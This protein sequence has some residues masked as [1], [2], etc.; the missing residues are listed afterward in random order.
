MKQLDTFLGHLADQTDKACLKPR[1]DARGVSL[2]APALFKHKLVVSRAR[3]RLVTLPSPNKELPLISDMGD[4][5]ALFNQMRANPD[6]KLCFE[7]SKVN[8]QWASVPFGI[9]VC[10]ECAGTH[11]SLGV[12]LRYGLWKIPD[13]PLSFVRSLTM[14][15]WNDKQL[16]SMRSGGNT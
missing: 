2:K 1:S 13:S 6:N 14:D 12:H 10:L 11:R 15:S 8:P 3:D 7:C 5:V 4:A 9:I 16:A